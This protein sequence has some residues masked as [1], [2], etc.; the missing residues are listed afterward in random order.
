MDSDTMKQGHLH[1]FTLIELL[2]V[3]AIIAILASMLLPALGKA[4]EKAR[5][6]SCVNLEKQLGV[7]IV[8]YA[9]DNVEHFPINDLNNRSWDDYLAGYDGRKDDPI[10]GLN[11]TDDTFAQMTK[12]CVTHANKHCKGRILSMLEG[13]YNPEGLASASVAHVKALA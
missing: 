6:I 3:I 1:R 2:V 11:W 10:G 5:L 13:G 9:D 12:R 7:A 4:E 8:L